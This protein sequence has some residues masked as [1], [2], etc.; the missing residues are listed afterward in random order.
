M[1]RPATA[2][3]PES[4]SAEQMRQLTRWCAEHRNHSIAN[5]L[6]KLDDLVEECLDWARAKGVR[7]ADWVA[8]VRNWVRI[9]ARSTPGWSPAGGGPVYRRSGSRSPVRTGRPVVTRS[10]WESVR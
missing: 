5:L 10:L 8:Q 1:T 7:R 6:P 4:L 3:P 9:S 2:A